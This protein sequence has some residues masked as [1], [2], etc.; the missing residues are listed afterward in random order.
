[1]TTDDRQLHETLEQAASAIDA[2]DALLVTAGAGMGVDSGLPD[3]RSE[4]GFWRAYPRLKALGLSFE[5][6]AQPRWFRDDARMAWAF[7][8]H[9][10]M[11]YRRTSPHAGFAR[12]LRA[13]QSKRAGYFVY[14][15]NVD[16]Q[17]ETAGFATDRVVGCHGSI[18]HEQCV[19]A[20]TGAIWAAPDREFDIDAATFRVRGDLPR[21]PRCDLLAR[22]NVLMFMDDAWIPKRTDLAWSRLLAWL[23]TLR[24]AKLA[25]VELG[26]GNHLPAVRSFSEQV[27]RSHSAT[28]VRINPR[29][30]NGPPGTLSIALPAR[31]ALE[32][33]AS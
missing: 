33:M 3:F 1:M 4:G 30:A 25:I 15:S 27:A 12:L 7:Y 11:L 20:C 31:A 9:R 26:A 21:C 10:Q 16:G 2:A 23:A 22:P 29:A 24:A 14:T 32:R 19:R 28:L 6:M 18:H 8:G 13:A 5:E 17:F